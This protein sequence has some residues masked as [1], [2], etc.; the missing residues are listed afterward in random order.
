MYS[1]N[2]LILENSFLKYWSGCGSTAGGGSRDMS[3]MHVVSRIHTFGQ[4]LFW[5]DNSCE[6][7]DRSVSSF[8][9]QIFHYFTGFVLTQVCSL[10]FMTAAAWFYRTRRCY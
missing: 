4:A 9:T 3:D 8:I 1:K 2:V 10:T 7:P 6:K 5:S